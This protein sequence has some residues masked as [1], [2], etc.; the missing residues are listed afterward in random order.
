[1]A[2]NYNT[3]QRKWILKQYWKLENAEHVRTAWQKAFQTPPPSRKTIYHIRDKF[4]TLGSVCNAPKSG[5]PKTSMT[6]ENE[7]LV[8]MTFVNSPKKS[9]RRASQQL[10]IPR[11]SLRRLMDKLKLK[12]YR[13]R[14]VHGLLEDDPDRRLQFCESILG[15]ITNEQPDL[16]DKII[17]SDEACFKLSGHVNRH[18]CV[19]WTDKN[20]HLTIESQLNQPGVT[21]WGALSSEGVIGPVFFD[22]TV[23]GD[24]YLEMLRDV[25]VP[26]LRTKANFDELYFQQDGAPPHYAKTVREYLHQVFPQHWFGRRGCIEWPPRSPDMTPMDFFFWGVV[27]NKVYERNPH[28]VNELKDYI[29]DAFTEI[30]GD[31]NLCRTVCQS[32]LDSYRDCCKV[33]GGHFEHLRD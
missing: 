4:E 9:T 6:E 16:L 7:M 23:T 28:T 10:S 21:T 14:L 5:R 20:P 8:A 25:V 26:Q 18:N 17:W 12:P 31:R 11:T 1:M 3:E 15:H 27:K 32:V 13:P 30:D 29:S 33:E 24:N 19:Y 22:G 2:N